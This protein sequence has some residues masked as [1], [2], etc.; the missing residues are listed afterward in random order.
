MDVIQENPSV[1]SIENDGMVIQ[2]DVLDYE[3]RINLFGNHEYR[4][5]GIINGALNFVSTDAFEIDF[6]D[7][8]RFASIVPQTIQDINATWL[9]EASI[10]FSEPAF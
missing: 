7:A 6:I 8:C 3:Q 9:S 10:S 5:A 1:F 2:N 4:F